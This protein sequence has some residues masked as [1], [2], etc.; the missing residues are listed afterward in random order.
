MTVTVDN[1]DLEAATQKGIIVVNSPDGN[2]MAASEHTIALMLAMARNVAPAATSTKEGKWE[3]SKF[4]GTEL[5]K[6]TLGIIGFGKIGSHVGEVAMALGMKVVVYDPFTSKEV[7]EKLGGEYIENL[8]NFWGRPDFI[9][10]HVPKTKDTLN[11][12]NKDTI[13]K[14]KQG[15]RLINCARGGIINE[16]DLK[17]AI[18]SGYVA[19][20][21]IDVY[22]NEPNIQE[23]PLIQCEK[24]IVLTPHLGASTTEAQMNVAI[25]VAEQIKEVLSG[26]IICPSDFKFSVECKSYANISFWDLFNESSDLHSWMK[27]CSEDAEFTNKIPLLVVKINNHKPFVGT[28][29]CAE[30]YI[31]EHK[32]FYFYTL[33]DFLRLD[34][35]AFFGS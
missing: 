34:D 35:T 16:N 3:R 5:Y 25:D 28:T 23:C 21:A 30:N 27:Q 29:L 10:V 13:A 2:T 15:V 8:D 1:I 32:R 18:N 17:E 9:T 14:M 24:N 26:D 22:E 11:M 6:K 12:I 7:V 19:G 33:E 4:V 31:L 20:A